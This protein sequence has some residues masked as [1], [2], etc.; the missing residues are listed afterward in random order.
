MKLSA[1]KIPLIF[2]LF[3]S[4]TNLFLISLVILAPLL[5]PRLPQFSA[6]LYAAFAP[7]CHQLPE[8]CFWLGQAPLALCGRCFGIISGFF[9]GVVL[10]P[11]LGSLSNLNLPSPRWLLGFSLP[12]AVDTIANLTHFW[13]TSNWP[14]FFTGLIWG[15]VLPFYFFPAVNSLWLAR[16]RRKNKGGGSNT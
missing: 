2:W 8:R 12:I 1:A 6:S 4:V 7:F 5:R 15:A 16:L 9:L 11:L 13:V 10:Y 3:I 14:R